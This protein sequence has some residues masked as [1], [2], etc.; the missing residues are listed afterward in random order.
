MEWR[1]T[2]PLALDRPPVP[3]KRNARLAANFMASG[4]SGSVS[5]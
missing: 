1:V 3:A 4:R 2:W 5:R